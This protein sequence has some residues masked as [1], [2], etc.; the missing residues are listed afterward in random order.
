MPA[1]LHGCTTPPNGPYAEHRAADGHGRRVPR[2]SEGRPLEV[3]ERSF[4]L[5]VCDPAPLSLD[6]RA[7]G[8]GLPHGVP[9]VR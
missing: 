6:G 8:H 4:R 7:V 1:A 2:P 3:L 9:I 5:L